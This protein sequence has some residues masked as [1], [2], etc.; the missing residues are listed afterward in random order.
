MDYDSLDFA[1]IAGPFFTAFNSLAG[2]VLSFVGGVRPVR[3]CLAT[4]GL[5]AVVLILVVMVVVVVVL[6]LVLL[7]LILLILVII[8]IIIIRILSYL[9]VVV[10]VSDYPHPRTRRDQYFSCS[11]MTDVFFHKVLDLRVLQ[12]RAQGG[13]A[14][15]GM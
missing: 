14:L 10:V 12:S 4:S 5:V 1:L 8:I 6:H 11:I 15:S 13:G 2:V 3:V 9:L 7:V